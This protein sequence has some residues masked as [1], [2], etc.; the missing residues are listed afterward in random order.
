MQIYDLSWLVKVETCGEFFDDLCAL[1][2]L[3]E[4]RGSNGSYYEDG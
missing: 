3:I 1:S 2:T 4:I